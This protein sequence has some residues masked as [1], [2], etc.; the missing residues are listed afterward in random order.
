MN[1]AMY[2]EEMDI[3]RTNSTWELMAMRKALS[4]MADFNDEREA[5]R[6]AAVTTL[7]RERRL[8]TKPRNKTHA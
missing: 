7:L 5:A 8:N 2:A 1:E 4:F 6:L 3:H